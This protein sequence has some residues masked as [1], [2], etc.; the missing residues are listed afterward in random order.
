MQLTFS[1]SKIYR[2][3]MIQPFVTS[4]ALRVSYRSKIRSWQSTLNI[5]ELVILTQA[6]NWFGIEPE[7]KGKVISIG[8]VG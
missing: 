6:G 8:S 2:T 4:E 7:A 3:Y 5:L 1:L